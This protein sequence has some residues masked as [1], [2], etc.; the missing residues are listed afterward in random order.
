VNVQNGKVQVESRPVTLSFGDES[1]VGINRKKKLFRLSVLLH[2]MVSSRRTM[3][4]KAG[5]QLDLINQSIN[6]LIHTR[7]NSMQGLTDPYHRQQ[8][9]L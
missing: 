5:A 7:S 6:P 8:Y 3:V 1:S 2:G 4:S 9:I